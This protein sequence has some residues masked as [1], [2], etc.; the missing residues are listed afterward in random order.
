M[1]CANWETLLAQ[2]QQTEVFQGLSMG[3]L[4]TLSAH[5]EAITIAGNTSLLSPSKA[6]HYLY[7][8]LQGEM[9]VVHGPSE[10]VPIAILKPGSCCGELSWL[11]E[12]NPC[13]YVISNGTCEL[14]RLDQGALN[15]LIQASPQLCLNLLRLLSAR[16][17]L[18]NQSLQNSERHANIDSLTGLFNRRRLED[19]YERESGRCGYDNLPL[20]LL[21]LDV[22][23]FKDYNDQHGHIAGDFALMLVADILRRELR[24]TDSIAR[25]G[26]EEFVILL[27]ELSAREST[28]VGK[29]LRKRLASTTE[30]HCPMGTLPGVTAS[31]GIAQMRTGDSLISLISRA[32][33][34]LYR[35]KEGGRN[36]L[37]RA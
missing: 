32:D 36:R 11:E 34:A 1:S 33:R 20:N 30:F 10:S 12:Q 17:R 14:L 29:R 4:R 37:C 21:I 22:D 16:L 35:A 9:R 5:T 19:I 2:L 6:N 8:L 7:I 27:P 26:G 18:S 15:D 13:A 25:F 3:A 28:S 31:I 23:F 24:P